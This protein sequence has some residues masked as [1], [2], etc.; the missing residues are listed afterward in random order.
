[1]STAHNAMIEGRSVA[2]IIADKILWETQDH[3]T[4]E[5]RVIL[6]LALGAK[7]GM[8]TNGPKGFFLPRVLGFCKRIIERRCMFEFKQRIM[9]WV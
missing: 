8:I 4:L 3:K 6:A 1:L 5:N 9:L 7:D 2:H